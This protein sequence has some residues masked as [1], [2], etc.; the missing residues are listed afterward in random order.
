M[1]NDTLNTLQTL[2]LTVKKAELKIMN[3]HLENV[4]HAYTAPAHTVRANNAKA[5]LV[6]Q[7]VTRCDRAG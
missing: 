1:G 3:Y 4:S 2:N 6:D 7:Q 5:P